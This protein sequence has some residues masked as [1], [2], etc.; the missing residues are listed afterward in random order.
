MAD[1]EVIKSPHDIRRSVLT[2]LYE[3]GMPLKKIQEFAGHSSLKQTMDYIRI[4]DED[5]DMMQYLNK[6]SSEHPDTIISFHEYAREY[7]MLNKVE[8]N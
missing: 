3:A 8:Q 4:T 1:M 6:L 5:L 7:L 2:T